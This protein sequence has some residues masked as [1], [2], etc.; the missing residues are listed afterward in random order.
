MSLLPQIKKRTE[1]DNIR[2]RLACVEGKSYSKGGYN[3]NQLYKIAK[4]LNPHTTRS[5]DKKEKLI[6]IIL[7][8]L[9][10]FQSK[11]KSA[12]P[13]KPPK[14]SP[15]KPPKVSPPKPQKTKIINTGI[16]PDIASRD[17]V[18][19]G[20]IHGDFKVLLKIMKHAKLIDSKLNWIGKTTHVVQM[21]DIHDLL[22]CKLDPKED[23][24]NESNIIN[25]LINLDNQAILVGGRVLFL[26]GNHEIMNIYGE[27]DYVSP[28]SIMFDPELSSKDTS[29][30]SKQKIYR[31][32]QFK[33]GGKY[34]KKISK[35]YGIIK[36]GPYIFTHAGGFNSPAIFSLGIK[37]INSIL[38][39]FILGKDVPNFECTQILQLLEDRSLV[40][41]LQSSS[42]TSVNNSK[43]LLDNILSSFGG[44][45]LVVGHTPHSKI[46][47]YV[48]GKLYCVDVGLSV[49]FKCFSESS[50]NSPQYLR[51]LKNKAH[52]IKI[53]SKIK[54]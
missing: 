30:V 23:Q 2:L 3:T 14:V 16:F 37:K 28:K 51:I 20:D 24:H 7:K 4:H 42:I 36:I 18:A 45:I 1:I 53:K 32:Q 6:K 49:G 11:R 52:S 26:I 25:F 35:G 43:I 29:S 41:G 22:R 33:I 48:G 15:P 44:H 40:N 19:I 10:K 34:A 8:E 31:K 17:I 54:S 46:T 47:S 21:G 27:F 12:S 13:P 5:T 50:N 9:V 38:K 39:Q